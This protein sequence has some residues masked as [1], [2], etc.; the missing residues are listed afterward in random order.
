MDESL[1]SSEVEK[2]V[3]RG[4]RSIFLWY[5]VARVFS[6]VGT[7][8]IAKLVAPQQFGIF[9]LGVSLLSALE[10]LTIGGI[11][12]A[13]VRAPGRIESSTFESCQNLQL[14]V[15]IFGF[16][17]AFYIVPV[18]IDYSEMDAT[19][20]TFFYT[21]LSCIF[22]KAAKASPKAVLERNFKQDILVK[23]EAMELLIYVCLSIG[24][25]FGGF[26]IWALLIATLAR[27]FFGCTV[28]YIRISI[29]A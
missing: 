6:L 10:A 25:A 3:A 16:A 21:L 23:I 2:R 15:A 11:N 26:G 1:E 17:I 12:S 8:I 29:A 20:N 19:Y 18:L 5:G 24:L 4:T 7:L 13:L 9:V 27:H 22:L 28:N 14:M